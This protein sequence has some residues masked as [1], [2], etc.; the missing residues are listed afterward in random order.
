[1][2]RQK[3]VD[4][5][6]CPRLAACPLSRAPY[7]GRL[8][9]HLRETAIDYRRW[10]LTAA[11]PPRRQLAQRV[12][13]PAHAQDDA[14]ALRPLVAQPAG[15]PPVWRAR[16]SP[17]R[18]VGGSAPARLVAGVVPDRPLPGVA[19]PRST[20]YRAKLAARPRRNARQRRRGPGRGSMELTADEASPR[21]TSAFVST[22]GSPLA[23]DMP[24]CRTMGRRTL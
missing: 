13:G 18:S 14:I 19:R 6:G 22:T 9:H 24:E 10:H 2:R 12:A 7:G 17:P 5:T 15:F 23:R 8:R 21:M 1:M 4:V 3:K 20:R 16:T 11:S